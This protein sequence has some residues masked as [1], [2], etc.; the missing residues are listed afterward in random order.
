[1]ANYTTASKV[2]VLLGYDSFTTTTR[3]TLAQTEAIITDVTSEIDFVLSS[4]GITVQPTNSNILGRLDLACK[5][6]SAAQ[7][8]MATI[9]NA[10]S[11]TGSQGNTYKIWYDEILNEIKTNPD[12][13]GAITGDTVSYMSNAVHDGTITQAQY[14]STFVD[15]DYRY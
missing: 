14:D 7:I 3:P 4:V 8:G 10:D 15:T 11:T 13:Y 1:M 6:G 12:F 9:G 5:Y 2:A